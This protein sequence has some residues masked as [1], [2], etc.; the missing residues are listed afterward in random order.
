MKTKTDIV[1]KLNWDRLTKPFLQMCV[2]L[3]RNRDLL[4]FEAFSEKHGEYGADVDVSDLHTV[5]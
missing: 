5:S 1:V 2:K 3:N 4:N